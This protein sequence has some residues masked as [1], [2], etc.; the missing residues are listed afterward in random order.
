M[1]EKKTFVVNAEA[2]NYVKINRPDAKYDKWQVTAIVSKAEKKRIQK[3]FTNF[4]KVFK[5]YDPEEYLK[6]FKVET[7]LPNEDEVFAVTFEQNVSGKNKKGE[8]ISFEQPKVILDLGNGKGKEITDQNVGN[9]SKGLVLVIH[10]VSN[11]EGTAKD[12]LRLK[13]LK[14]TDWVEY[15]GG[16]SSAIAD[17]FGFEDVEE[18]ERPT[19][20]SAADEFEQEFND[21]PEDDGED[22]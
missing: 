19:S 8:T 11:Y 17:E 2:L 16:G 15:D 7:P 1:A 10:S 9:G 13:A 4:K 5:E 3:Q 22:Y 12:V 21:A 14:V 18:L 20:K 6:T